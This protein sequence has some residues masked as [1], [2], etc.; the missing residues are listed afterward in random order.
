MCL[1]RNYVAMQTLSELFAYEALVTIL[2][3]SVSDDLKAAAV[4][5]IIYLHV[6]RDPQIQLTI[7]CL[8]RTWSDICK[9]EIPLLP[10]VDVGRRN[11][12]GLLQ[13]I[14]SVHLKQMADN[15]WTEYSLQI[16]TLLLYL[17]KFNFFG[18]IERT[19]DLVGPLLSAL[20]RRNVIR[21]VTN[22]SK[23]VTSS[24]RLSR[25]ASLNDVTLEEGAADEA[26][27]QEV[28][29]QL[30][31]E[32]ALQY[33]REKRIFE[34]LESIQ[35][36]IAILSLVLVAVALTIYMV[37]SGY[38]DY[39]GSVLYNIGVVISGIFII[40]VI[41]RMF[42]YRRIKGTIISFFSSVFNNIDIIVCIIDI[43]F[44]CMP[45]PKVDT[46]DVTANGTE[47]KNESSKQGKF[48]KTARMIRL[49]RLIRVFRGAKLLHA[50]I[51][52]KDIIV[53]GFVNP[54][55]YEK[56]PVHE[57]KTMVEIVN[58]LAF[59]QKMVEDRNVSILLR[60]FHKWDEG[61]GSA[62]EI[63]SGIETE[64]CQLTLQ[65]DKLNAILIDTVMYDDA[66]LVQ[67][68]LDITTSFYAS[69]SILMQ[70]AEH[71]QLLV[72][73]KRERQFKQID[74]MLRQLESNAETQELW[75]AL[76]TE[77]D[78]NKCKQT[79]EILD[80]LLFAVRST[81]NVLEFDEEFVPEPDIQNLL[82]NV[83]FFDIAFKVYDLRECFEED[84]EGNLTESGANT[85]QIVT[86]CNTIMYWFLLDNPRNQGLAFRKMDFFMDTLDDNIGSHQ[87][88]RAIFRNNEQLMKKCP[89]EEIAAAFGK[90]MKNGRRPQ[91][92]MLLSSITYCGDK[93]IVENQYEVIR[94][95]TH[96][97]KLPK[98]LSFICP[99]T[100]KLSYVLNL[101]FS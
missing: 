41:T 20:D 79:K 36:M 70:N 60:A 64:C 1:D 5:L 94:T 54:L 96:P 101:F 97:S 47:N 68:I 58:V 24:L 6:D 12:F 65:S 3:L 8:T 81:R 66:G 90:I 39:P 40:E 44:L 33:P 93:N 88:I 49:V 26:S 18:S 25:E 31:R 42:C 78:K 11:N 2:K 50:L 86:K 51:D 4:H 57:I 15:P 74:T 69:R 89:R 28:R 48:I 35:V 9:N 99:T 32:L 71:V 80:E 76:V 27:A 53:D 59:I 85:K 62:E 100:C 7:P 14:I 75:G 72:S 87:I 56:S 45:S 46:A 95:L 52:V 34:F 77:D 37:V 55:R 83:G 73:S 91:Y 22:S 38:N 63:F 84:D 19:Q 23:N 21:N 10:Y 30:E 82:H 17:V 98:V 13:E 29:E 92:L 43:A 16:C 67:V 61:G